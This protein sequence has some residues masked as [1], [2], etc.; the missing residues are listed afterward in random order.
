MSGEYLLQVPLDA[1]GVDEFEPG[2]P[3]KVVVK[4]QDGELHAKTV[5]LNQN[6]TGMAKFAF[7]EKPGSA[8]VMV[9]PD[10]AS[11]E[12]MEGLRTL[13]VNVSPRLWREKELKLRPVIITPYYWR[14]WLIWCRTFTIRGRVECADGTGVPGA[15]VCAYDIDWWWWWTSKQ[16]V[17]CATT[18]QDGNFEIKFTWCCWWW[19][20]WW[21][22]K[23]FWHL[24][25]KL[26]KLINPLIK[27]TPDLRVMPTPGPKVNLDVFKPIL[28]KEFAP[29]E[30]QPSRITVPSR[31]E[32]P[33]IRPSLTEVQ[34]SVRPTLVKPKEVINFNQLP[35]LREQLLERLPRSEHL[36][37]LRIWPWW[38]WY[39]W[40][41]CTPDII[42]K[43]TQDC[44]G[45]KVIVDENFSDVRYLTK[46]VMDI[47]PLVANEDA[48]CGGEPPEIPGDCVD[49][50]HVCSVNTPL[51]SIGGNI[52]APIAAPK[53][54]LNPALESDSGDRPYAGNVT[55]WGN[56]GAAAN[57]DYYEFEYENP[58]NSGNWEPLPSQSMSGF[59]RTY[60]GPDLSNPGHSKLYAASF[61][62]ETIDGHYVIKSRPYYENVHGG[63]WGLGADHLWTSY[64]RDLLLLWLT[65]N[66]FSNGLYKLRLKA[67]QLVGGQLDPPAGVVLEQ[68]SIMPKQD[69]H[70]LLRTDNRVSLGSAHRHDC[71]SGSVHSCVNEP[72]TEFISVKLRRPDST[73]VNVSA[74]GSYTVGEDD[75]LIIDFAAHDPEGHLSYYT[76]NV[77]YGDSY[78]RNLLN[79]SLDWWSLNPGPASLPWAPIAA[80]KGPG[81]EEARKFQGAA[82]P[83]W[84]G[85]TLR[86]EVRAREA[87]PDTCCYQLELR[88]HKRT[89]VNCSHSLWGHT[90]YSEYSFMINRG[91]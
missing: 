16:E 32:L 69:N 47:P 41:D 67:Y 48:C 29:F 33:V 1:S 56:F 14:W 51:S 40:R 76:L 78:I 72:D 27:E 86:L 12:E 18:D 77:T 5:K 30:V 50:S 49:I 19:P 79:S 80:Q 59:K 53:G 8:V 57:A 84:Y 39:P 7:K 85:G 75:M 20:W 17:G 3:V 11:D 31:Y 46:T 44:E 82:A 61:P 64:N 2:K 63:S 91:K 25:P 73:E 45:E 66:N 6:G 42:F 71:G 87:F 13:R 15:N 52:G 83:Y 34:P 74:C 88:A 81:Y 35:K 70:V 24:D 89:I 37:K 43:V 62:V 90:N 36:H 58:L 54:Y 28:D 4:T 38:P 21:W 68:C 60:H 10:N 23:R 9:G 26:V 55:I 22:R 65:Q